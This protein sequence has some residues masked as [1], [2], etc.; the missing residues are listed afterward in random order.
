MC[1][2][3]DAREGLGEGGQAEQP[4]ERHQTTGDRR[5]PSV[6]FGVLPEHDCTNVA[7]LERPAH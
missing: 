4:R 2:F 6:T 3:N 5:E 1:C 7:N